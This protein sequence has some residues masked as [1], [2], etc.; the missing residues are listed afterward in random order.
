[1]V[2]ELMDARRAVKVAK[3]NQDAKGLAAA[4]RAVNDAKVG[5]GERGPVWWTDGAE[6]LNRHMVKNT[7]YA[8]WFAG[9]QLP[10]S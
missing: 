2:N 4:R 7:A 3:A 5:L 9:T 10:K 6:D 8:E 1:M